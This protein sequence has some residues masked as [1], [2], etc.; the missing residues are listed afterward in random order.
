[1]NIWQAIKLELAERFGTFEAWNGWLV[2]VPW[3]MG[4]LWYGI[5][6]EEL[7]LQY[8]IFHE[9][10]GFNFAMCSTG[11]ALVV[12]GIRKGTVNRVKQEIKSELRVRKRLALTGELDGGE[13]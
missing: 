3:G 11:I 13:A 1:M 8:S 7:L 5:P 10:F 12:W 6:S 4:L 9:R 2:F